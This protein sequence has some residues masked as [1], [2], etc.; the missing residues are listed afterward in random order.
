VLAA[1]G[2]R[3]ARVAVEQPR[4]HCVEAVAALKQLTSRRLRTPPLAA[5]RHG[6]LNNRQDS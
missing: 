4:S 1:L 2:Q 5:G 3:R 6:S